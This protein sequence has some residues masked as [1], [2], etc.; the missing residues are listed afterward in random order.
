LRCGQKVK[1]IRI[2]TCNSDSRGH[3][4]KNPLEALGA[5]IL[6]WDK[7]R[8]MDDEKNFKEAFPL[9]K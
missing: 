9:G 1:R 4:G 6:I 8:A 5:K 7:K 3:F 2:L